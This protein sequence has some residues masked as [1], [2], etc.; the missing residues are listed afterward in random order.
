MIRVEKDAYWIRIQISETRLIETICRIGHS[1]LK[2]GTVNRT[3][4]FDS[5]DFG[6][7]VMKSNIN[8]R[9]N[10][11]QVSDYHDQVSESSQP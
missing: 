4:N 9:G 11:K 2:S 8:S 3:F 10:C 7:E 6:V 1:R 5:H